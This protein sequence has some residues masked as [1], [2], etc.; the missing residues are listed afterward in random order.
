MIMEDS[1]I[2]NRVWIEMHR[3][4][5]WL[6]QI[7]L[8]THRKRHNAKVVTF[9]IIATSLLSVLCAIIQ[10]FIHSNLQ[11]YA[12]IC[13]WIIGISSI[14]AALSTVVRDFMPQVTQPESEICE[15]DKLHDFYTD[16]L[17]QLEI[18]FM[19]RYSSD[20]EMNDKKLTN[21]FTRIAKSEGDNQSRMNRLIRGLTNSEKKTID[22]RTVNYFQVTFN[23]R[24][25]EQ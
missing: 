3:I 23:N 13:N 10:P 19:Q 15:L 25:Y 5:S 18:V 12:F 2:V 6:I 9:L 17:H 21:C 20:P 11:E 4:K 14:T 1:F 16:Y 8:Y 24:K 7:E 22:E